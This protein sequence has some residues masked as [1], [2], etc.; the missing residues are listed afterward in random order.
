MLQVMHGDAGWHGN[1]WSL[2]ALTSK[3]HCIETAAFTEAFVIQLQWLLAALPFLRWPVSARKS[4]E[5]QLLM[6]REGQRFRFRNVI[7][8]T[9][10]GKCT[11]V[12]KCRIHSHHRASRVTC[13]WAAEER[14]HGGS[15]FQRSLVTKLGSCTMI[16]W[17]HYMCHMCYMSHHHFS[18][19]A[20][21]SCWPH[22]G[23]LGDR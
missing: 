13:T 7:S 14:L 8:S 17:C 5:D 10:I 20:L 1:F 6:Q 16:T 2:V 11:L 15:R 19:L 4:R 18:I 3:L 9:L 12:S 22:N 21:E 23:T